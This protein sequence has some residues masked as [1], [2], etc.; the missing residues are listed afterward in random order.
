[1]KFK[2][3]LWLDTETFCEVP[4]TRGTDVYARAVEI[5]IAA[6][7]LDAGPWLVH[8]CTE[9]EFAQGVLP[10]HLPADLRDALLDPEC[11]IV[12]HNAYFDRTVIR[13]AWGLDIPP[14][15]WHCTMA[16]AYAHSLPGGL[17]LLCQ[18]LA[19]KNRKQADG[20]EHI[21]LFCKPRPKNMKARRATRDTHP[22]EWAAFMEY[23]G[24]D[25]ASMRDC[26]YAMP[27]RNYKG[28]EKALWDLDQLINDTGLCIDTEFAEAA[29]ELLNAD[30][31]TMDAK[32][33]EL[34]GG[35]VTAATQRDKFLRHLLMDYGVMLDSLK[36]DD[37]EEMIKEDWL[38]KEV[39]ELLKLRITA[40][41]NSTSKYKRLL[42]SVGPDGRLRGTRQYNGASRTGR[43]AGRIFN[44]LNLRR[45][46]MKAD[47]I[48]LCIDMIKRRDADDIDLVAD[49]LREAC[50]NAL[51]GLVIAPEGSKLDVSDWSGIEAR[52]AAW[53][54]GETWKLDAFRAFD[55]GT[56]ADSYKLTYHKSFGTPVDKVTGF[57]RQIGKGEDLSLQYG[58]GVGA[59]IAVSYSYGLDLDELGRVMPNLAPWEAIAQARAIYQW[60]L[61]KNKT[62][63][64][65]EPVYVAC[66]TVKALWR[67]ANPNFVKGWGDLEN[68]ARF[69]IGNR[70][71]EFAACRCVFKLEADYLTIRLPSGRHLMYPT[72]RITADGTITYAGAVNKQWKRIKTYGGKFLENIS[73]AS[74]R[75]ILVHCMLRLQRE[76]GDAMRIVLDVYDEVV[77]EAPLTGSFDLETMNRI[78]VDNPPWAAGLPLAVEGW[79]GTRYAKR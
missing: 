51:R 20:K 67:L 24:Y 2:R 63:G 42:N 10:G 29:V 57:Q 71:Q 28:D 16:Q 27:S 17:G 37:L 54:V 5:M 73:Q 19:V 65:S 69:A 41:M 31:V 75:D 23:A 8:D 76:H 68:A 79:E 48:E 26:F 46:S 44:P 12:A 14:E 18:V 62:L 77:A 43:S 49:N 1:V 58:G 25:V 59:F 72:P 6:Y 38:P 66:E 52:K 35:E 36:A 22:V 78:L 64:L 45:P 9:Y 47:D 53:L 7:A 32:I 61:K 30:K 4:I 21:N 15:R 13:W 74:S 39:K 40:A 55:A 60:A 34:T 11:L 70:G 33:S 50:S 56:G 3:T